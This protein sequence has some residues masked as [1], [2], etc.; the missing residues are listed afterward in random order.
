MQSF[1]F[2]TQRWWIWVGVAYL[3]AFFFVMTLLGGFALKYF[4]PEKARPNVPEDEKKSPEDQVLQ[5]VREQISISTRSLG[6][7]PRVQALLL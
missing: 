5:A 1:A 4:N 2:F 6:T 3:I 7:Y